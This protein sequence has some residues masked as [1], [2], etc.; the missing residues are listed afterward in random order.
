MDPPWD[1]KFRFALH[2]V[3]LQPAPGQEEEKDG[4]EDWADYSQGAFYPP[5]PQFVLMLHLPIVLIETLV[6]F[7]IRLLEYELEET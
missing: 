7:H 5:V 2:L 3:P 4:D 1:G 6:F